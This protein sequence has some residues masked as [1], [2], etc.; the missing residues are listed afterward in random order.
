MKKSLIFE[1][2][3]RIIT[4]I[5][6]LSSLLIFW[7]GHQLPGGGFIGGL[8]VGSVFAIYSFCFG[9]KQTLSYMR[10]SPL[11][12]I[13]A[14]LFC[15]L[16]SGVL[17]LFNG[18]VAFQGIWIE[19]PILGKI[20]TPVLFDFGVYLLVAGTVSVFSIETLRWEE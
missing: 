13:T 19:A 9:T 10:L 6:L 17:P 18:L 14:G 15:A 4:P 11:S 8:V 20:G 12:F 3:L 7:R 16:L 5:I 1:V 2:S